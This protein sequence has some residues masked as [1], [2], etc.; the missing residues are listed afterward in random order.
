MTRLFTIII[1]SVLM[2]SS[3]QQKQIDKDK[4]RINE[5]C[6]SFMQEFS[7]G[8]IPKAIDL[9]KQNSVLSP[10]TLDTIQV[11]IVNQLNISLPEYGKMIS[12]DFVS[13]HKVKDYIE[14]RFYILKFEKYYLKFDFTLYKSINGW[15]ITMFNFNDELIELL[16]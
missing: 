11:Q 16:Y 2:I 14:R 9:I 15:T 10:S 7:S 6:D 4:E 13:E 1:S 5:V 12:Y 8:N 3:C